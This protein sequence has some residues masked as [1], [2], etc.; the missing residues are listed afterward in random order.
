MPNEQFSSLAIWII[1]SLTAS[2]APTDPVT[3]P[4]PSG[5][6]APV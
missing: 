4:H 3:R 1:T 6:A 2:D 5:P